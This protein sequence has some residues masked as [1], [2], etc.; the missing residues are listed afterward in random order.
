MERAE[1][2][3]G[4]GQSVQVGPCKSCEGLGFSSE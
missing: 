2:L 4:I 3:E 1:T